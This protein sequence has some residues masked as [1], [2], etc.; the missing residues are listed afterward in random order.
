[1]PTRHIPQTTRTI[2]N[3]IE[4]NAPVSAV[5]KA[6]TDA[7]EL[8]RWFPL[9]AKVTPGQD[10]TITWSWGEEFHVEVEIQLWKPNEQLRV[11]CDQ[12]VPGAAQTGEGVPPMASLA[13]DFMLEGRGGTTL[14]R[15]V[16]SGFGVDEKWDEWF[17][18]TRRGWEF[19]LR[20][21]RHYLE[22]HAGTP[23]KI[24]WARREMKTPMEEA[25]SRVM[26]PNGVLAEGALHNPG[27]GDR[28]TITTADGDVFEGSVHLYNPPKDFSATVDNLNNALLRFRLD[29]SSRDRSC[30]EANL[31]LSAYG[32]AHENVAAFEERWNARLKKLF[33]EA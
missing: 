33:P 32:F 4:I 17:A 9:Q 18:S 2:E 27:E 23:R 10:G 26:G 11:A 20:G 28:Y 30:I 19:E 21:L 7:E 29:H 12:P 6:L 8:T 1:M 15:V 31:W 24:A 13:C 25:W 14:L 5:W 22:N 16:N 3:E